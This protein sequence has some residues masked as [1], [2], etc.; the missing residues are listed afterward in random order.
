M[1]L[2]LALPN[3]YGETVK[4]GTTCAADALREAR[5]WRHEVKRRKTEWWLTNCG[6]LRGQEYTQALA[7]IRE[8]LERARRMHRSSILDARVHGP[9]WVPGQDPEPRRFPRRV[10]WSGVQTAR[11]GGVS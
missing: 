4:G 8:R 6:P 5:Y 7:E 3:S 1:L 9:S 10:R 11:L 2:N